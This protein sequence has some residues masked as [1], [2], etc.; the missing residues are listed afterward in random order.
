MSAE[1]WGAEFAAPD[2]ALA[3]YRAPARYSSLLH[4]KGSLPGET[5]R[6]MRRAADAVRLG[7]EQALSDSDRAALFFVEHILLSADADFYRMFGLERG[8]DEVSIRDRYRLMMRVLHPD[9]CGWLGLDAEGLAARVNKAHDTLR[10]PRR[11]AEYDLGL[12]QAVVREATPRSGRHAPRARARPRAAVEPLLSKLPY[13]V[14]RHV[15][16]FV[17]GAVAMAGALLVLGAYFSGPPAGAIGGG[18]GVG[19]AELARL[20]WNEPAS[21]APPTREEPPA[22]VAKLS[23]EAAPAANRPAMAAEPSVKSA[24][25]APQMP[26]AARAPD[27][28]SAPAPQ[29]PDLPSSR[30]PQPAAEP[31]P[32]LAP[33]VAGA[34]DEASARGVDAPDPQ[35]PAVVAAVASTRADPVEARSVVAPPQPP[36]PPQAQPQP[37]PKQANPAPL[38]LL[39]ADELVRRFVELYRVGDIERFMSLFAAD[40]RSSSGDR[41]SIRRDY[42]ALFAAS[43]ERRMVLPRV[44]WLLAD[45]TGRGDAQFSI[46]VVRDGRERALAGTLRLEVVKSQGRAL[47]A[48][49]YHQEIPVEAPRATELAAAPA[50]AP[51]PPKDSPAVVE[52]AGQSAPAPGLTRSEAGALIEQLIATYR[53][54]QL[55]QFMALFA[56]DA[57]SGSGDRSAI[58]KD[59]EKLFG[60]TG[61]RRLMLRN[62]V[63]QLAGNSGQAEGEF[64]IRLLRNG[65]TEERVFVGTIHIEIVRQGNRALIR[66]LTHETT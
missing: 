54:G 4:G 46:H 3:I 57:R 7:S 16:Q 31:R 49:L 23:P 43:S 66:K 40:A 8:A 41:A 45:D 32:V 58:S 27:A 2:L 21:E 28:A 36:E 17:L 51:S 29:P 65:E 18:R 12:R 61:E 59:Y 64:L 56:P 33:A 35:R 39:E 50:P 26:A 19:N 6:I 13:V 42:A 63:W 9:R 47:I 24:S 10:D 22:R 14:Q 53:A 15:P 38:A 44:E 52:T 48:G 60:S 11:R 34:A 37:Q 62:V 20:H 25:D 55:D 1:T 5:E 30:N